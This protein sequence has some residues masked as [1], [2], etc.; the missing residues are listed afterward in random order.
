MKRFTD[1]KHWHDNFE[2]GRWVYVKLR[3]YRQVLVLR[4]AHHKLTKRFFRPFEIIQCI[5]KVA[6][7]P[8]SP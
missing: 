2:V 3:P 6:Y 8:R 1:S 7:H 4:S 5:G